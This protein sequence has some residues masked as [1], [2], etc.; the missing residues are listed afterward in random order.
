MTDSAGT[1]PTP[2]EASVRDRM[3]EVVDAIGAVET[4]FINGMRDV[5]MKTVK[6]IRIDRM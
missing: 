4:G 1:A 6:I 5:P 2:Q 3:A